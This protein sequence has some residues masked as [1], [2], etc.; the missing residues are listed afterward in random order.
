M[1]C[2]LIFP[3]KIRFAIVKFMFIFYSF[4]IYVQLNNE[5]RNVGQKQVVGTFK[6][7]YLRTLKAVCMYLSESICH[8]VSTI[9]LIPFAGFHECFTHLAVMVAPFFSQSGLPLFSC[10]SSSFLSIL[11]PFYYN[12]RPI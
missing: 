1:S 2:S 7:Q 12:L 11:I 8:F 9:L 6:I 5:T 3:L 4:T 10:H